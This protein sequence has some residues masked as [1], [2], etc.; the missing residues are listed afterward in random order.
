MRYDSRTIALHWLTAGLVIALWVIGQTA[1]FIPRGPLRGA[2]WSLHFT[3]GFLFVAVLLVRIVWRGSG[4]SHLP[5]AESGPL[6]IAATGTHYLLYALFIAVAALGVANAFAHGIS[7]FG[8]VHLPRL[9]DRELGR[10]IGEWHELAANGVLALAAL[11]AAAGLAHHYLRRDTVL[12]RM[13]PD[14]DLRGSK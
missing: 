12:Q 7:I 1:D 6:Q 5:P 13:L 4:G 10:R 3:L 9:G 8:I 11:H 14:H 2:Y